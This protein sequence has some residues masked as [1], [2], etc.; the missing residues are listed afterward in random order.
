[1]TNIL[2]NTEYFDEDWASPTLTSYINPQSRVLLMPLSYQEGWASDEDAWRERYQE[3]GEEI[4]A[5]YRM[6]RFTSLITMKKTGTVP[7]RN[8]RMWTLCIWLDAIRN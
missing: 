4:N 8:C 3:P 5:Y 6:S 2:L 7:P 1:M